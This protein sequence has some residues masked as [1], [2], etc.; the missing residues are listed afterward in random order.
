LTD[1]VACLFAAPP[2]S[3]NLRFLQVVMVVRKSF[4]SLLPPFN[5]SLADAYGRCDVV[6]L[7]GI[8]ETGI[9]MANQLVPSDLLQKCDRILFITHLALGDYTYL[10]NCFKAF[11]QRYPGI[12]VHLWTDEVLRTTDSSKWEYLK[13]QALYDWL[14]ACPYF[15]KIYNRTYCPQLFQESI[16]EAQQRHYPLVVSLATLRPH[17][18]ARLARKISPEGYVAG[19]RKPAGILALH[20]RLAYRQLDAALPM[21]TVSKANP[22]HISD[23]HAD[24][25]HQLFGIQIEPD[26]RFPFVQIPDQ[27]SRGAQQTLAEWGFAGRSG[28]PGKL[29]KLVFINP[30]AKTQ[31]R[32]WPLDHVVQLI[33]GMSARDKWRD[34]CFIVNAMPQQV[35]TA[36][37]VLADHGLERTRVFSAQESFFQLPA[38]LGLCDLVISVETAVMH[39]ANAVHVPVIALMRQKT[40]EWAPIDRVN[41]TVIE[42]ARRRDWVKEITVEQVMGVL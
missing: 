19:I 28:K 16:V 34:A 8:D 29:G 12:R 39:L 9:P 33:K 4:S 22:R 20:H 11:A 14:D 6:A 23:I 31:K 7:P 18:Y 40:P 35:D 3:V 2:C 24:W 37:Q 15:E 10:Q 17:Q 38:M 32:C 5:A 41:S 1:G 21:Y 27:W 42:T 30:Y 25:F 36:K 13:K 26:A